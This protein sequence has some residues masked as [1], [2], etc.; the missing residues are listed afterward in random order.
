MRNI[1]VTFHNQYCNIVVSS[2][3]DF[4]TLNGK[5]MCLFTIYLIIADGNF[6]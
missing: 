6:V 1:Y 3:R 4:N 5:N 2:I